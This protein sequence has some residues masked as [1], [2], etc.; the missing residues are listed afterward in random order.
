MHGVA[1]F[2]PLGFFMLLLLILVLLHFI[3]LGF[4]ITE[5]LKLR[6]LF[7]S[8]NRYKAKITSVVS[9]GGNNDNFFQL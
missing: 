3:L 9:L 2:N 1:Q 4:L 7:K 6:S 8:D 5:F